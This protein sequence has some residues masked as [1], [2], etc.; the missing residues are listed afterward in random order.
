MIKI[1]KF[2]MTRSAMIWS[3]LQIQSDMF[4]QD[5]PDRVHDGVDLIHVKS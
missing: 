1:A 2:L 4:G 3:L 5:C